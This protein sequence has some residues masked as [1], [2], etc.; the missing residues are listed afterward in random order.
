VFGYNFFVVVEIDV[1][2]DN[3]FFN[4]VQTPRD[5][6]SLR[7]EPNVIVD[8]ILY[9]SSHGLNHTEGQDSDNKMRN[10]FIEILHR[11]YQEESALYNQYAF[12]IINEMRARHSLVS[13]QSRPISRASCVRSGSGF[14]SSEKIEANVTAALPIFKDILNALMHDQEALEG[15]NKKKEKEAFIFKVL[16]SAATIV[17]GI[18]SVILPTVKC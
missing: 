4:D 8:Y 2:Y 14:D 3:D 6:Q 15:S 13:S 18:L 7:I 5:L 16:F 9:G 10:K 1:I 12:C 11:R 17:T